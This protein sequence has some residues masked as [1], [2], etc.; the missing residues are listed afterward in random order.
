M[1]E[2]VDVLQI[3]R[4]VLLE[5]RKGLEKLGIG[6]SVLRRLQTVRGLS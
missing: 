3:F 1:L 5:G 6:R 2:Y 4:K